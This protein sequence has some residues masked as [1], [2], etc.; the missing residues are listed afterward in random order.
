MLAHRSPAPPNALSKRRP[1]ATRFARAVLIAG[2]LLT[3]VSA[4]LQLSW[5]IKPAVPKPL[6]DLLIVN[7][8]ISILS[9]LTLT[10]MFVLG[11]SCLAAARLDRRPGW[12][13]IGALFLFLSMDDC[14]TLHERLGWLLESAKGDSPVY[15]WL[16]VLGPILAVL[17]LFTFGYLWRR[18][19]DDLR[20]RVTTLAGFGCLALAL[21]CELV[22]RR[23]AH[24][25]WRLRGFP[26]ARYTV[27]VEELLELV[28][29]MLILIPIGVL[30]ERLI[31]AAILED[32]ARDEELAAESARSRAAAAPP[33]RVA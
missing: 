4:S 12:L 33:K 22:E 32:A 1:V 31:V 30:L 7:R 25:P 2:L 27:H 5:S 9:W 3:L 15:W 26:L 16:R 18:F 17:G 24:S 21:G 6:Q 20:A 29:P 13:P 10:V 14:T 23:L 19:A 11:L 28:G 8:D